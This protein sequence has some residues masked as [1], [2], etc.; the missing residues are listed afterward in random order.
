MNMQYIIWL[1]GAVAVGACIVWLIRTRKPV[2]ALAASETDV[3][4]ITPIAT[5]V[6]PTDFEAIE[7]N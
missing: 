5:L 4:Q 3:P 6:Q 7:P 2:T 1:G